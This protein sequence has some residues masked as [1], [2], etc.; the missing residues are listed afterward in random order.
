MIQPPQDLANNL[1]HLHEVHQ[2][3]NRIELRTLHGHTHPIVMSM[4][5]F[6]LALVAAQGMP[7]GKRFF[8][9]N[10]KH[11]SPGLLCPLSRIFFLGT[12]QAG[13]AEFAAFSLPLP[14]RNRATSANSCVAL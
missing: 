10:L 2:Q 11:V 9:A 7:G 13:L 4:R 1:L 6:A 5:V 3:T 8:Y 14:S 12:L